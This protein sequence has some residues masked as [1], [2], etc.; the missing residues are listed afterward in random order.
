MAIK[1][2]G[3]SSGPR[4][5]GNTDTLLRECLRGAASAGGDCEYLSLKG[6]TIAPCVECNACYRTGACWQKDDYHAVLAKMVEADR[7]VFATPIFFMSVCSQGKLLIDRCQCLWS[8][9]YMLKEPMFTTPRPDRHALVIAAGGSKSRKM[10]DSIVLTMKYYFDVLDFTYAGNL[11]FN[12]LD[13]KDAVAGRPEALAMAFQTGAR[14]AQLHDDPPGALAFSI[15]D[16]HI[17][18]P[19]H[20]KP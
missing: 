14:L 12:R 9:K 8:R 5:G 19:P 2:L 11:F 1:V 6:L 13:A 17:P 18:R 10:F 7:L 4:T 15:T 3:I 16:D 20:A